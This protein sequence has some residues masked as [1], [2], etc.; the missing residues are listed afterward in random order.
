MTIRP[1][2][3]SNRFWIF[4]GIVAILGIVFI[5]NRNQS[6]QLQSKIYAS[7]PD[8]V[9]RDQLV[10]LPL[11]IDTKNATINAAEINLSFNPKQVE[12]VSVTKENSLFQIW[13]EGEPKFSNTD[14]T[15][16]LAGGIPT[17]GFKGQG[18]VGSVTIKPKQKGLISFRYVQPTRLLLNDGS[19]TSVPVTLQ[20]INI[21]VQ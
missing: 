9:E 12:V 21:Y 16:S 4:L 7:L 11:M 2:R 17:P 3:I 19:G 15:L 13:I 10:T 6:L 8:S 5:S 18:Q 14:G 20:P 1:Q